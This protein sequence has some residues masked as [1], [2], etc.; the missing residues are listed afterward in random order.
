VTENEIG[1]DKK[2]IIYFHISSRVI[3]RD[4]ENNEPKKLR[5]K[6]RKMNAKPRRAKVF[7]RPTQR[8]GAPRASLA[9]SY[10]GVRRAGAECV[11]EVAEGKG[12]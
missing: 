10:R 5:G 12:D 8:A 2:I 6:E 4:Y 3:K 7:H 11:D 1:P 9:S